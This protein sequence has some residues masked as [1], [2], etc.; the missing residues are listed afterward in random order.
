M[1]VRKPRRFI[2][3]TITKSRECM[4]F[5]C[6]FVCCFRLGFVFVVCVCFLFV[7]FLLFCFV[8]VLVLLLF[9]LFYLFV[10]LC[11]FRF[12]SR[13]LYMCLQPKLECACFFVGS[14]LESSTCIISVS[15]P[16]PCYRGSTYRF[17]FHVV[18]VM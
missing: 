3:R 2:V 12:Q 9:Y 7:L 6:L 8:F 11:L 18:P 5:V 4:H 14:S 1:E 16:P 10:L 13:T 17:R 15:A